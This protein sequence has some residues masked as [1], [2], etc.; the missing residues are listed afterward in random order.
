MSLALEIFIFMKSFISVCWASQY[1]C[2]ISAQGFFLLKFFF[3]VVTHDVALGGSSLETIRAVVGASLFKR[4]NWIL[5]LL[6]DTKVSS[7]SQLTFS[8]NLVGLGLNVDDV[9][10]MICYINE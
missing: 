9:F 7:K 6:T 5:V 3:A 4:L 10:E 2:H 8:L 1:G